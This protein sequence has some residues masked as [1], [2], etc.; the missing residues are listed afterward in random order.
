MEKEKYLLHAYCKSGTLA[1]DLNIYHFFYYF[2]G[3]FTG[4]ILQMRKWKSQGIRPFLPSFFPPVPFHLT[5][6]PY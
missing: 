4:F 3:G 1:D 2:K 6:I 5:P